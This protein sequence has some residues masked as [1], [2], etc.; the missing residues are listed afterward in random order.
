MGKALSEAAAEGDN[1]TGLAVIRFIM[2][3]GF[4]RQEALAIERAWLLDAGGIDFP[5]TKSGAQVRPLGR[6]AMDVLSA[7]PKRGEGKWI[8]PSDQ[9]DGHF[10]G[11][12]NVLKRVCKRAGLGGVTPHVL[13]HTFASV[14]GDLGYSELTIAGLL[15]HANGSVTA[16]YVHLDTALIAA[17]DRISSI[18]AEALDEKCAAPWVRG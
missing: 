2:L 18:I 17:A 4:R 6:A 5:D 3:S 8:F 15:G 1:P 14:A 16:A 12:P 10:V 13:R 9:G 7:Q 11:V